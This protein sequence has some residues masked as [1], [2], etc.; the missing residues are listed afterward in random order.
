MLICILHFFCF[1]DIF[2]L[3]SINTQGLRTSNLRQAVFNLIKKKKDVIFFA[4]HSLDRWFKNDILREW[5]AATFCLII[6][7]IT[8]EGQLLFFTRLLISKFMKTCA[9]LLGEQSKHRWNM[10]TANLI[11]LTFMHHAQTLNTIFIFMRFQLFY[12]LQ[13]Q[14]SL[15]AILIVFLMITSTS[16][17]G[18]LSSDKQQI[19]YYI[20]LHNNTTWQVYDGTKKFTWTGKH[21]QNNSFIHTCIDKFY[22][23]SLLHYCNRHLTILLL[24]FK[25]SIMVLLK[26]QWLY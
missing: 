3:I 26:Q 15:Q 6:L 11:K 8:L 10:P 23:S 21:P 1:V 22:I 19:K 24:I 12:L 4:R 17:K 20:P 7:S 25:S 18:I 13:K 16:W 2:T 5:G 9:I 14:T